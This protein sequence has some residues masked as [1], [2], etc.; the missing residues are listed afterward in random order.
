MGF[1]ALEVVDSVAVV[2]MNRAPLNLLSRQMLTEL[3]STLEALRGDSSVSVVVIRSDISG[4]FSAGSDMKEF[5]EV[6]EDPL[7]RKILFEDYVLRYLERM[8]VP[9]IAEIDGHALGG[10]FELALACDLRVA[11]SSSKLGLPEVKIGGLGT[12]G[13][14]RLMGLVGRSRALDLVYTG[15]TVDAQ[16]ALQ[17]GLVNRVVDELP[18]AAHDASNL[19]RVIAGQSR[20]SLRFAKDLASQHANSTLEQFLDEGVRIQRD[21]FASPDLLAGSSAFLE[22]KEIRFPS[23]DAVQ[24][25]GAP[26]DS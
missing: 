22:K 11:T 1:V 17:L 16:E 18:D 9:T 12:N 24:S 5:A 15:R 19:G 25:E 2:R 26:H 7:N 3:H 4:V 13:L 6:S 21:V 10:G 23:H 20:S 8:P 14:V